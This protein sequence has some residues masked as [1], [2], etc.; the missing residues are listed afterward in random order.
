MV[1]FISCLDLRFLSLQ[2]LDFYFLYFLYTSNNTITLI[3][4]IIT[5]LF[6]PVIELI[7]PLELSTKNQKQ[8]WKY[9]QQLQKLNKESFQCNLEPV[10]HYLLFH[11][12][13]FL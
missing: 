6:I 7:I 13:L 4:P 8:K 5:Q 9:I 11:F 12:G 10:V 2:L 1:H 3:S